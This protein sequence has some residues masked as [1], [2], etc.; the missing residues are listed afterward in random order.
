M[1]QWMGR[2]REGANGV[3]E[4]IVLA[5]R[6]KTGIRRQKGQEA[7]LGIVI[8]CDN[9]TQL[10]ASNISDRKAV[11][12]L[13]SRSFHPKTEEPPSTGRWAL[14]WFRALKTWRPSLQWVRACS[15]L[16]KGSI[17]R[18]CWAWCNG[19]CSLHRRVA[20]PWTI[21]PKT[22]HSILGSQGCDHIF[23]LPVLCHE[24]A[25]RSQWRRTSSLIS[26][27]ILYWDSLPG[28]QWSQSVIF[29]MDLPWSLEGCLFLFF[30]STVYFLEHF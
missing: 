17:T 10:R 27:P 12:S 18:S 30:K 16:K 22:R 26:G 9:P 20:C 7:H 8:I 4:A 24:W 15:H 28:P 21:S 3:K 25:H 1:C 6:G 29:Q 23:L 2:H 13:H 14:L 19:R 11:H 5:R